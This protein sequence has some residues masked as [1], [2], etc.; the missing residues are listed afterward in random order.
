MIR[1]FNHYLSVRT[2]LLAA[3]E[4]MVLFQSV[5]LVFQLRVADFSLRLP[6]AE[7]G[8]FTSVM[9]LMMTALGL[10]QAQAE[11]FRVT[12][13]RVLVAYGLSLVLMS[14]FFYVFPSFYVGRG[15]FLVSSLF[16][17]AGVMVVRLVFFRMTDIGLP[18]RRV[19]VL[20]NG[21]EAEEIIR[22]LHEGE[23]VRAV[24]YAGMYPVVAERETGEPERRI[25]HD[26]LMRT[27]RD[28][29]VSEIVIAV[30]DRRGGV[31]PLRQLLDARLTG[32]R[33]MD[34]AAFY[35]RERGMLKVDNLRASWLIFGQGF[36]QGMTRDVVKR[37]FDVVVSL[38]MLV[39]TL[40]ILLVT[41]LLIVLET[42]F[43]V[44]YRQ[45][46]VGQAGVPFTIYKLRSMR[47]DA[48]KDG[49]PQWATTGDNRC[50]RVGRF[51][52]LTRIDELP[53]LFNVLRGDMSFVGPRPERPFF[54]QQLITDIPYYDIRHSVKPGVTGWSQVRYPYGA[55]VEDSLA[56]LQ[57]DLY[58]VKNHSLFLDLLILVETAQVVLL[59][60]GAR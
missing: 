35:E 54:V 52:R 55:S 57:Y 33:V 16:A 15:A 44:F 40:P 45:E 4:A 47:Q 21:P 26:Q 11:P 39:L 13:Q 34:L 60:T 56:K 58:Y 25:N 8:V 5:V 41:M 6:V 22:Y 17:M 28:L 51:I 1:L 59:G 2:L 14:F 7:A 38:V 37:L 24:Q 36:D 10:Y 9:L 32:V 29:R 43:P 18:R 30:R 49:R 27:V 48:E 3:I 53:Q 50:T 19:L 23:L 31:L 20:G 12:V 46:R 42:G